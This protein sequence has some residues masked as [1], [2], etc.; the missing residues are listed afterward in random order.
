MK[1]DHVRGRTGEVKHLGRCARHKDVIA[2]DGDGFGLGLRQ[3]LGP[4][5]S[6]HQHQA[7]VDLSIHSCGTEKNGRA[8][9]ES[10]QH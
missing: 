1:L 2:V 8:K 4:D 6:M 3:I 10:L 7:G 9:N 5:V